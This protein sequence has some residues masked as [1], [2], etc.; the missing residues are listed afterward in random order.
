MKDI[1]SQG[2]FPLITLKTFHAAS[3]VGV[4]VGRDRG[5]VRRRDRGCDRGVVV[6]VQVVAKHNIERRTR[7]EVLLLQQHR[8]LF[9]C[10][11][12]RRE[13]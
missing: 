11:E 10:C 6:S 7:V 9:A 4:I 8:V 12:A 5:V 2:I 3:C 1:K 13:S